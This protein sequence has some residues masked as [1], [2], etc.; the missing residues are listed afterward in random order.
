MNKRRI[1]FCLS[2]LVIILQNKAN[3]LEIIHTQAHQEK[4]YQEYLATKA[5]ERNTQLENYY[6]STINRLEAEISCI[7][8]KKNSQEPPP[9]KKKKQ[10]NK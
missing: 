2:W 7:L 10:I 8:G 3:I 6:E 9:P 5:K 1:H 4:V